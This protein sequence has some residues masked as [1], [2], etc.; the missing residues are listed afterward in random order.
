VP[1]D[2]RTEV[3]RRFEAYLKAMSYPFEFGRIRARA[4]G[5]ITASLWAAPHIYLM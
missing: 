4:K 1:Q 5:R 2:N 3:E